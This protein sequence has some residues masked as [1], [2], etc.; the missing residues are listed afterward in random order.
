MLL[1]RR[2]LV[3]FGAITVLL[4]LASY[5]YLGNG[6]ENIYGEIINYWSA[7]VLFTVYACVPVALSA[8]PGASRGALGGRPNG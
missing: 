6:L 4:P 8:I 7:A 2:E 5:L 3:T 1:P